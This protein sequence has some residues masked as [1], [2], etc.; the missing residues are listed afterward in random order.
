MASSV[1]VVASD[2]G[3]LPE[4]IEHGVTGFLAPLGDVDKM[5]EYAIRILSDCSIC[6]AFSKAARQRAIERFDYHDIIP[7][8]EAV[9]EKA[10]QQ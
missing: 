7:Q 4:V 5:A 10:L 3:G 8:Y 1:P 2:V 9:Y 6:Q